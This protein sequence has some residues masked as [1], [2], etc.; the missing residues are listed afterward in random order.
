VRRPEQVLSDRR[1]RPP[2]EAQ[3]ARNAAR[4]AADEHDLRGGDRNVGG[5]FPIAMPRSAR[6]SA[7]ASFTAVADHSRPVPLLLQLRDDLRLLLRP[8]LGADLIDAEQ[9]SRSLQRCL[10]RRPT[11][12]G[13]RAERSDLFDRLRRG[14]FATSATARTAPGCP[15]MVATSVVRP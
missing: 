10:A 3:R 15:S 5:H 2:R 7:G 13:A 1:D 12:Q 11:Q 4:V 8:H 6:A 9:L 14:G